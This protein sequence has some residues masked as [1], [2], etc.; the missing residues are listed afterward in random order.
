[1]HST[2]GEDLEKVK[3]GEKPKVFTPEK[4]KARKKRKVSTSGLYVNLHCISVDEVPS[5]YAT[6]DQRLKLKALF[7]LFGITNL[8]GN[9]ARLVLSLDHGHTKLRVG[10]RSHEA[11]MRAAF[12]QPWIVF[13]LFVPSKLVLL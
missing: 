11:E 8:E 4:V 5:D 2:K 9:I 6:A 3:D 13:E 10:V 12:P 7:G 1:M